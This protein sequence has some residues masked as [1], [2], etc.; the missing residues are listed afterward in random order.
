MHALDDG[1]LL[2][3]EIADG[4]NEALEAQKRKD[5]KNDRAAKRKHQDFQ[6]RRKHVKLHLQ[7]GTRACMCVDDETARRTLLAK[8]LTIDN[9]LSVQTQ[10][11][12]V[13][14]PAKLDKQQSWIAALTGAVVCSIESV[15]KEA[16][17]FLKY[18]AA[19]ETK[20]HIF[21]TPEFQAKHTLI[22][23]K[24]PSQQRLEASQRRKCI[25]G[26]DIR[27]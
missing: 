23:N 2:P 16:G 11:M 13:R 26:R 24:S 12:V 9:D 6:N 27:R 15:F 20:K 14:Y 21:L 10:V 19:I 3:H 17:P 7:A 22:T 8:R 1:L 4:M 5:A 25:Q 18:T